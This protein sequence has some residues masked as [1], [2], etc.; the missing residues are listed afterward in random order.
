[1]SKNTLHFDKI[2]YLIKKFRLYAF[3]IDLAFFRGNP[4]F[5][6]SSS[7]IL[8]LKLLKDTPPDPSVKGSGGDIFVGAVVATTGQGAY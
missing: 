6:Y 8:S 3:Y 2:F 5:K 4:L 1:M 7:L